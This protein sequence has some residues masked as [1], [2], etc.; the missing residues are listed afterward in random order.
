MS[1]ELSIYTGFWVNWSSGRVFGS[2]L[3]LSADNSAFLIAFIALFVRF[4]GGQLWSVITFLASRACSTAEPRDALYHQQQAVLRNT[5]QPVD[6]VWSMLK[7]AWFWKG[8]A[9]KAS[10]RTLS[11]VTSSLA[12][13]AA[14]ALAG[15]FSSRVSSA[16][17][18]VLLLPNNHCGF[19]HY[20]RSR[21]FDPAKESWPDYTYQKTQ[22]TA[23]YNQLVQQSHVY[24]SECYNKTIGGQTQAC[25]PFGRDRIGWTTDLNAKC[26]FSPEMC[27][28]KAISLDTGFIGSRSHF[29]INSHTDEIEYRRVMACAPITTEGFVSG[30]VDSGEL[31][32]AAESGGF[33][34]H[35][36]F[37]KYSY[38]QGTLFT[39]NTTYAF[40]NLSWGYSAGWNLPFRIYDI[41]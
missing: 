39:D 29:G 35:E 19:W 18:E 4:V 27:L 7:L 21:D 16:N 30:Y 34:E 9:S 11:F 22:Y 17:S 14:F 28:T 6:L 40:S 15:I 8:F 10:T 41:E 3:T 5:S 31:A 25:L 33:Y 20:P 24:V 26:P 13:I 36:T 38:G 2:T 1:A 32:M 23:N 12:Y 37:L